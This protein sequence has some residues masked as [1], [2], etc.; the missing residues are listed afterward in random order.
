VRLERKTLQRIGVYYPN[1]HN[2]L[3]IH[4]LA[5]TEILIQKLSYLNYCH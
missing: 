1:T 4:F 5:H 2:H 3:A